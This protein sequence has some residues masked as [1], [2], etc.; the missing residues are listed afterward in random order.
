MRA[1]RFAEAVPVLEQLIETGRGA[2]FERAMAYDRR[3]FGAQ[4]QGALATCHWNLGNR[5]LSRRWFER[6][7]ASEPGAIEYRVKAAVLL[8]FGKSAASTEPSRGRAKSAP[9]GASR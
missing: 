9:F 7:A 5:A 6:A 1:R 4:A 3:L 8:G 2:T